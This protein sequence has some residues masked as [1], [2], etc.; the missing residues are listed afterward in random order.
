MKNIVAV[1]LVLAS[2]A[3]SAQSS[4]TLY[5]IADMNIAS[6]KSA[7]TGERTTQVNSSGIYE[8]RIGFKGSEDLGGGLKAN[9]QLEQGIAMDTGAAN[10]FSRQSWV[11]VSGDFG[12]FKAGKAW[13][14]FDEISGASQA[15]KNSMFAPNAGGVWLTGSYKDNPNSGLYYETPTFGGVSGAVSYG[16]GKGGEGSVAS[17]FVKYANGPVYAGFAQQNEKGTDASDPI[18]FTRLN[19]SYDLGVAKLLASYGRVAAS[20]K[21]TKEWQL[22]VNVPVGPA[23]LISGGVAR[24][25]GGITGYSPADNYIGKVVNVTAAGA[26]DVA[27]TGYG[28][29]AFYTMSKRTSLYGGFQAHTTKVPGAADADGN[30]VA[31][32]VLHQF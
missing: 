5:G 7:D 19:G 32:G 6:R 13:S 26:P 9:F 25:S 3:A 27:R 29:A 30:V 20:G 23:W 17:M 12:T 4:V 8:S 22:G 11:G 18:K 24:S 2:G 10:G 15:A 21:A 28:I 31:V 16:L 14:A 1:S